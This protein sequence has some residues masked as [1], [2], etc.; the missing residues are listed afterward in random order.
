MVKVMLREYQKSYGKMNVSEDEAFEYFVNHTILRSHQPEAFGVINDICDLICVD[1]QNDMGID[2][3]A[4][5]VNDIFISTKEDIDS[6]ISLYR[7]IKIE[8]IF[9]QSKY[10]EKFDTGE[11][12]KFVDGITDFLQMEHNEP[13]NE[14]IEHWI[15]LKN[16]LLSEDIMTTW[17][18]IPDIRLYYVVMG[19]WNNN[20]HIIAKTEN[21]KRNIERM[22]TY[23]TVI[24]RYIDSGALIKMCEEN[25]NNFSAVLNTIDSFQLTEVEDVDNSII[26][27]CNATEII[28]MLQSSDEL[29]R[30][31]L[32]TDNVRD[33]QGD[34]TINGEIL[35]TVKENPQQFVLMNNGITIVCNK[36]ISSN[37]KVTITSPQVVN[38]C[39]T[40]NVLYSAFKQGCSLDN[41]VVTVKVIATQKSEITNQIVRGTNRQNIVLDEAFEITR[42][43]H[44][45]L[46]NFFLSM[47][48]KG[49]DY[50]KIYY[51]R[52][53]KQ[54]ADNPT[55]LATQKINFRLLIQSVVSIFLQK[56]YQAYMHEAKLLQEFQNTLFVDNQ[57]LFPYYVAPCLLL[58]MDE[59]CRE[60]ADRKFCRTYKYQILFITAIKI[61]GFPPNINKEK[62]I[63]N[64]CKKIVDVFSKKEMLKQNVEKAIFCFNKI[65]EEWVKE[66]GRSYYHGVKSNQDFNDYLIK[67]LHIVEKDIVE[68]KNVQHSVQEYR[69]TVLKVLLDKK[70][71]YYGFISRMPENIFFHKNDNTKLEF[72]KLYARDVI[73]VIK[74]DF[75]GNERA[76]IT[77]VL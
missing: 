29:L 66:K 44:K 34:T 39:Q 8:F 72:S 76:V 67:S 51:E 18:D 26:M 53:S 27:M 30:K 71:Q 57:S 73:Y 1:G 36:A 56:P 7:K 21:L 10:K 47:P 77:K 28:K 49:E 23:G 60:R 5:K 15:E 54:Y 45:N 41:V 14:K 37:R 65:V 35:K 25:D 16:Y 33:F 69:G 68:E 63:D 3:I 61:A 17:Q 12:G 52:R 42:D 6:I 75:K 58:M 9:I 59:I 38:G 2:G 62:L 24:E 55:I 32:F 11:Y 40:C 13:H 50:E 64:Y 20:E 74:R 46:E 70:N 31:S 48:S 22:K 43:F 4:I 19:K